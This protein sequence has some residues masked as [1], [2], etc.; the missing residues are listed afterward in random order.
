MPALDGYAMPPE[1]SAHARTWMAW[2]RRAALWGDRLDEA[3]DAFA[4]VAR[5]I[6]A[7]EPVTMVTTP[8]LV[9]EVSVRCGQGVATLALAHDDSWMRDTGPTFIVNP[10]G[11]VAGIHWRFNAW[12]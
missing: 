5:A 7:F 8:D 1:W 3:C 6:V 12:G 9:A 11:E 10:E 4:E 2:P